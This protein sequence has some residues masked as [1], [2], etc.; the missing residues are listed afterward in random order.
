MKPRLFV[1]SSAEQ[2]ELAYAIQEGLEHD[3]ETT[4]WSQGVFRLSKT[5]LASLLDKLDETDFGV[6]LFAPDD[7]T[8]LRQRE[9]AAVRD[10]VI[11]E[12]GLFVGR[13]GAEKCFIIAPMGVEDLRFPTDLLGLTP[14]FFDAERQD[15]NMVAALGPACNRIRK[16]LKQFVGPPSASSRPVLEQPNSATLT[17]EENDCIS[18]IQS[19]MGARPSADNIRVM[20]FDVIDRELGLEPGSARKYVKLAAQRWHYVVEREGQDT[21]LFKDY[22]SAGG[23]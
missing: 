2:L 18:I 5:A 7:V 13:L 6:F 12:L 10:N 15:A 21:I 16:I 1:A 3:A 14:A 8:E 4:V 23:Y 19:W 20:R 11:F 22:G 17:S 9:V